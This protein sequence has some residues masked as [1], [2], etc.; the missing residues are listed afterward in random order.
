[1]AD[2]GPLVLRL[3]TESSGL[4]Q[5]LDKAAARTAQLGRSADRMAA[6]L[7][8]QA[9]TFG[10]S[11]RQAQIYALKMDGAT[12]AQ[13]SAAQA[14][15]K[16][17][18]SLEKQKTLTGKLAEGGLAAARVIGGTLGTVLTG[19]FSKASEAIGTVGQLTSLIPGPVG[20]VA[21]VLTGLLGSALNAIN[22]KHERMSRVA[23]GAYSAMSTGART[24]G[25]SLEDVRLDSLGEGLERIA[26]RA[27]DMPGF[28][29]EAF[30]NAP[31]GGQF[32][33]QRAVEAV[34][35]EAT[36]A[37]AIF[38][39][40]RDNP[41]MRGLQ[42]QILAERTA[43]RFHDLAG[44]LA[45]GGRPEEQGQLANLADQ[46]ALQAQLLATGSTMPEA[47]DA[48]ERLGMAQRF[49]VE[50]GIRLDQAQ[51]RL[52]EGLDAVARRQ[53]DLARAREAVQ[54]VAETR[55][56]LEVWM[57]ESRRLQDL[58]ERGLIDEATLG[59]GMARAA[60]QMMQAAGDIPGGAAAMLEGSTQ[61]ALAIAQARRQQER[62]DPGLRMERA[63]RELQNQAGI[64]GEYQ[65]ELLNVVRQGLGGIANL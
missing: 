39:Q 35:R 28:M 64:R 13:L 31:A 25:Q 16:H 5:G 2:L 24:A 58:R 54:L 4:E 60:E 20:A 14:A 40:L 56:P 61:A 47:A 38:R 1:M 59:R 63:V 65:R 48:A 9:A 27:A 19:K 32:G 46:A 11:G 17:L 22:A 62:E 57:R 34:V 37:E 44:R 29:R 42:Q 21:S 49:A 43:Q 3:E 10:M 33:A 53:L 18:T 51:L 50:Q 15:D 26:R 45:Q 7:S 12:D 36:Q 30:A 55:S 8:R 23:L 52:A 41:A 6:D